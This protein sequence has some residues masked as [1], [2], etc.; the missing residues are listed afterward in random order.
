MQ[1]DFA[2]EVCGHVIQDPLISVKHLVLDVP[3]VQ[4]PGQAGALDIGLGQLVQG[5]WGGARAPHLSEEAE[6]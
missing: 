1:T 3:G 2:Q 4:L 5:Q 6:T